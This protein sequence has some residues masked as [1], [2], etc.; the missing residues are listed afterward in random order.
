MIPLGELELLLPRH[1]SL[2]ARMICWIGTRLFRILPTQSE[3]GVCGQ[4]RLVI[5]AD[6]QLRPHERKRRYNAALQKP[7]GKVRSLLL[8]PGNLGLLVGTIA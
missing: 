3:L 4:P 2:I 1:Y 5:C 7:G 8:L 6:R